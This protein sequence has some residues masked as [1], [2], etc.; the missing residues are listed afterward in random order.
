MKI[1]MEKIKQIRKVVAKL[2]LLFA[3][4]VITPPF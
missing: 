2:T 1:Y 4:V 3:I